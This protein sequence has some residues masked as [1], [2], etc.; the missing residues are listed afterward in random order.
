[1]QNVAAD[2]PDRSQ[3][4]A[5][6]MQNPTHAHEYANI[7]ATWEDFDS[8]PKLASLADAMQHKKQAQQEKRKNIANVTNKVAAITLVF[9]MSIFGFQTW[10]TWQAQPL[11]QIAK[12]TEI[13]QIIEQQL[14]DGSKITLNANSEVEVTYYRDKRLVKLKRGEAIFE[15]AK[16]AERLLLLTANCAYYCTRH[17]LFSK[18]IKRTR[19]GCS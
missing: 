18:P 17:T 11:M 4:E 14:T 19:S 13:G 1:M 7:T 3:F 2:H 6:L 8:T 15:V 9:V 10:Q 5:W 16:N 12:T